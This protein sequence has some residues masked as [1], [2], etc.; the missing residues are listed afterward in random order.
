MN[1]FGFGLIFSIWIWQALNN[2]TFF[3]FWFTIVG[4]YLYK[5]LQYNKKWPNS[6][7]QK[8]RLSCF[9]DGGDP[10]VYSKEEVDITNIEKFIEDFNQKNPNDKITMTHVVAR[11]LGACLSCTG[12][13]HGLVQYGHFT[14]V[15]SVD[16]SV[17]VDIGGNN[18]GAVVV[19]NCQ[20]ATLQEISQQL[21]GSISKLKT[22][23]DEKFNEQVKILS[24]IPSSITQLISRF[25]SFL[26]YD[27]GLDV[28]AFKLEKVPFG[29]CILTNVSGMNIED[30]TPPL[31]PFMKP[32][33]VTVMNKPV[34]KPVVIDGKIEIRKIMNLNC[35]FDHR[36]ADGCDAAKMF[37]A[38]RVVFNN[39]ENYLSK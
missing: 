37:A 18:L 8:W 31:V 27:L 35:S 15:E 12:R 19:K 21:K 28:P 29:M 2:W 30:S 10:C 20:K 4:V 16:I 36:F 32:V 33:C 34:F 26:A 9:K 6:A 17:L 13:N 1:F 5:N 14:P 25:V 22:G 24:N 11:G 3:I 7:Y 38:M 23:K 39:P